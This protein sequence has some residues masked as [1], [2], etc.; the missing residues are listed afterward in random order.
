MKDEKRRNI[1][2]AWAMEIKEKDADPDEILSIAAQVSKFIKGNAK[3]PR[4][5]TKLRRRRKAATIG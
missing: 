4:K 3:Q 5:T 2:I 1:A